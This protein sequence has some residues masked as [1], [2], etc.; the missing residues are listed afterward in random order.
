MFFDR[1]RLDKSI[2]DWETLLDIHRHLISNWKSSNNLNLFSRFG[3]VY[4]VSSDNYFLCT[5]DTARFNLRRRL[6]DDKSLEIS[7]NRF[8]LLHKERTRWLTSSTTS[9]LQRFF[10]MQIIRSFSLSTSVAFVDCFFQLIEHFRPDS[11][12]SFNFDQLTNIFYL[13]VRNSINQGQIKKFDINFRNYIFEVGWD[14][15][16]LCVEH[17]I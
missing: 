4:V 13:Q 9:Q 3:Y 17:S 14:L 7:I 5:R 6:L 11:Y 1:V 16:Q 15:A 10:F 12:N 8:I 2:E